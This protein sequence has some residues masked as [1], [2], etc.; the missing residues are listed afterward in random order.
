MS[1]HTWS[2]TTIQ[3]LTQPELRAFFRV[4]TR[5]RDRALFLL[6]YRHGLRASEVGLMHM[7]D[8]NFAQQR[9]TIHRLKRSLPGIYPLR[10]DEVNA[11][12]VY[13]RERQ[14]P[15]PTLFLSQRGTPISRRQ[16]DTLMKH[17]GELADI[18][19]SKRHF[20]VLKHSIATHLLDAGADLRFVQD[21]VG[22]ASIKNTVIYA[23]LTSRRRDEEARKVFTSPYVV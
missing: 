21:W 15:S 5:T 4:I 9:L 3:F 11:L 20:H 12:K 6:A 13:L 8:L 16:L 14:S 22:H 1:P 18:P 23:Q 19:A 7:D 17:Y 2:A 10:A